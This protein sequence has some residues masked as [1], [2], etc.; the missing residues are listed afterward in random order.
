MFDFSYPVPT[1][2]ILACSHPTA[3]RPPLTFVVDTTGSVKKDKDSIVQLSQRVVAE[4]VR[5]K[6]DVPR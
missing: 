6:I 5:R 1:L 2:H 4:I 3:T